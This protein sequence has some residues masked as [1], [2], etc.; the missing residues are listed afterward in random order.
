[1]SRR[2]ITLALIIGMT[3]I[4]NPAAINRSIR[5]KREAGAGPIQ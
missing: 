5:T 3:A 1:M 4:S 2:P